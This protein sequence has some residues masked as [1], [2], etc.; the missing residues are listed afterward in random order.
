[1]VTAGLIVSTGILIFIDPIVNIILKDSRTYYSMILLLP[2]I[3]VIAAASAVKGYYYGMQD[4][5][6]TACSQVVEQVVKIGIVIAMSAY[7]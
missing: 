3:P 1:M 7:F 2:C 6:P 4:V 5:V